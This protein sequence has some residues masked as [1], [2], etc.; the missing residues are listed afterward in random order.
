[1]IAQ[2]TQQFI[3]RRALDQLS[4][5]NLA[6]LEKREQAHANNIFQTIDPV[7]QDTILLGEM[8]KMDVLVKSYS[9]IDGLLEYS[10]YS[11]KGVA[12]YSSRPEILKSKKTLPDDLK[13]QLLSNRDKFA[14]QT[15]EAFEI[16]KPMV[17][18]AKCLECHD[19][20]K[21]GAIGGVA[22]VRI[23]NETLTSARTNWVSSTANIQGTN[24]TVATV[25]S[26]G[27]A[28]IIIILTFFAV[29]YLIT[30]PLDQIIASL[31]HGAERLHK[32]AGEIATTQN[33]L[34]D[35][36]SRQAA[37][38][39]ETGASLEELSSMTQRNA[40]HS[41]RANELAKQARTAADQ[42]VGDMQAMNA[43]VEAI[44]TSSDNT[45]KIIKTIDE[46]AFQT[47]ILA[48]NAAVEAARAGEAGLGFAVVAD[49]VRSLAQRSAQA[50]KETAAKIEGSI[51]RSAQGVQISHTVAKTL[52]EIV[53]KARQVDELAAEVANASREQTQGINQIHLAINQMDKVTQANASIAEES[54]IAAEDLHNQAETLR[55]TVMKLM[56]LVGGSGQG[57]GILPD[58]LCDSPVVTV[59]TKKVVLSPTRLSLDSREFRRLQGPPEN[60]DS[61]SDDNDEQER[62]E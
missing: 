45:A 51:A 26:I 28:V 57:N 16:Y 25:T 7:I 38:L 8:S 9:G 52:D 34:S 6:L 35:G 2:I 13:S 31:T 19:D 59:E 30:T 41:Q 3:N 40:D 4:R 1:V 50:A 17:V 43:A 49:E 11:Q 55:L 44:K 46:I 53:V 27:L 10:I 20:F 18:T 15:G 56:A 58:N 12:A 42:G 14:R 48:L 29:K 61:G 47:N 36:A 37:S 54:A 21:A 62:A 22:V 60:P 24:L 33:A 5:D 39:Q 23:S 32:S